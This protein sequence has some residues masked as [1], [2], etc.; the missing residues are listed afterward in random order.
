[1]VFDSLLYEDR[2]IETLA[3]S[4]SQ[5]TLVLFLGAGVSL[6]TGLPDWPSLIKSLRAEVGLPSD[7]IDDSADSLQLAADEVRREFKGSD[8]EFAALVQRHIYGGVKLDA[9]LLRD[10]L[11]IAIGA[12]MMGSRRGSVKR[13]VS[14]NF[15]SVLEWYISLYGFVP[16]VILHPPVDEGIEDVR[17][18]HPHGFLPHPDLELD[19]SDFVVLDLK[20]SNLR[21][22][23]PHDPWVVLLR[24]I[25]SSGVGLFVGLSERSF[26]DRALAPLLA[27]AGEQL[28]ER[29]PTGFWILK[30]KEESRPGLN[31][32]FL[33]YNVVPIHQ[34]EFGDIPKFLLRV[35][36]HAAKSIDIS[37]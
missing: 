16:R 11:L 29:R 19:G 17:I 1:M 8:R 23:K 33:D 21:L 34:S 24:H 30:S 32:E 31:K 3:D 4:L 5:G 13:V 18:Y 14:F 22:G 9:S 2:A 6:G 7:H 12:L 10:D 28:K 35:C 25:L 26:R 20:S 15:D 37:K 36:Q 27:E